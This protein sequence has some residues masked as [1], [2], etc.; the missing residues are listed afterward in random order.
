MV[1]FEKLFNS[2]NL[3]DE[4]VI[5]VK[6]VDV[7]TL[8]EAFRIRNSKA[9][10]SIIIFCI[11]FFVSIIL[12]MILRKVNINIGFIMLLLILAEACTL[13]YW[14][15]FSTSAYVNVIVKSAV[16]EILP[17]AEFN[18]R[19]HISVDELVSNSVVLQG[20]STEG[21]MYVYDRTS[22]NEFEYSNLKIVRR[23][24]SSK[25]NK[26][27][28]TV[29]F[30]GF[31]IKSRLSRNINNSVRV[32]TSYKSA[33]GE[34]T[35]YWPTKQKSEQLINVENIGFNKNFEVYSNNQQDAF[36]V[37]TP[38]VTEKIL[39]LRKRYNDFSIVVSGKDLY[40]AVKTK[41][42][43]LSVHTIST[44]EDIENI[45]IGDEVKKVK[46]MVNLTKGISSYISGKL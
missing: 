17:N 13:I 14:I 26:T 22:G 19:E 6:I 10:K 29:L 40:I 37:L 45:N 3:D 11:V 9:K 21:E 25:T 8:K 5:G 42:L 44:E 36:V 1:L 18:Y 35:Y 24:K 38:Y 46:F 15:H 4:R 34:K 41:N 12:S 28:T 32:I 2:F 31:V 27:K 43:P 7:E 33:L 30:D 23:Y 39:E 20:S 16:K